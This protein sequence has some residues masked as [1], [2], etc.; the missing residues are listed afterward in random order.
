MRKEPLVNGEVYHIYNKSIAGYKI[1]N[2]DFE[3]TR[4]IDLIF[5][6]QRENPG[7][8]FSDFIKSS[9]AKNDHFPLRKWEDGG[10]GKL[11]EIIAYCFMPTHIHLILKQLK[12]KGISTFMRK[13]L[14]SYSRYFNA[15]HGR[16]GPLWEG[17]FENLLVKT[18]EYLLHLTRYIHLNPTT[19]HLVDKPEQWLASSYRE[20]LLIK[21]NNRICGYEDILEVEPENYKKFIE[22]RVSYQR[23]LARIKH[24]LIDE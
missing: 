23:D 4:M 17:K 2:N 9:A 1:F 21:Y 3:F 19:A 24:L 6:Y 14:D 15:K 16:K 22:D 5:Y 12:E 20:Y 13:I 10:R 7:L 8:K 11:V 18:D